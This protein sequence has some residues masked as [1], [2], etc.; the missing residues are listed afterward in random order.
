MRPK[1]C[2]ATCRFL[3]K[4]LYTGPGQ[5]SQRVG[6]VC[7]ADHRGQG[8][9]P[10]T[11]RGG[12]VGAGQTGCLGLPADQG[13]RQGE[14]L[15]L[16]F[17]R[18]PGQSGDTRI[19]HKAILDPEG[20]GL[21]DGPPVE[22]AVHPVGIAEIHPLSQMR[23]PH[24]RGPCGTAQVG[25][26]ARHDHRRIEPLDHAFRQR[27][28]QGRAHRGIACEHP[29]QHMCGVLGGRVPIELRLQPV[30]GAQMGHVGT[31]RVGQELAG[32][33]IGGVEEMRLPGG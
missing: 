11:C 8:D 14:I 13:A 7:R 4:R 25:A 9:L 5:V 24:E 10:L 30:A 3:E 29:V 22:H 31:K 15:S 27:H 17:Q 6:T 28:P 21:M 26:L 19:R 20:A 1:R 33:R 2:L 18:Q 23:H 32:G 16:L 12:R